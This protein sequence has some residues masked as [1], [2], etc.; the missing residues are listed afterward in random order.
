[1]P[2]RNIFAAA[3]S[4]ANTVLGIGG[5]SRVTKWFCSVP[6]WAAERQTGRFR[7]RIYARGSTR[8][9]LWATGWC[10]R[11]FNG[12]AFDRRRCRQ[13]CLARRRGSGKL[14]RL[15]EKLRVEPM[16]RHLA[17]VRCAGRTWS[18]VFR[19]SG[20]PCPRIARIDRLAQSVEQFIP[21]IIVPPAAAVAQLNDVRAATLGLSVPSARDIVV[22]AW[23]PFRHDK[24]QTCPV[25][26]DE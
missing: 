5:L 25:C 9:R 11:R 6:R 17:R 8:H 15:A 23:L 14:A 4:S 21:S 12:G 13:H 19:E 10:R 16:L 26:R 20:K 18:F 3:L 22:R 2:F 1:M 7:H 24:D